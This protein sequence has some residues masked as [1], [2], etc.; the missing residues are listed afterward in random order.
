M[1][2][3]RSQENLFYTDKILEKKH[4]L[5]DNFRYPCNSEPY[6]SATLPFMNDHSRKNHRILLIFGDRWSEISIYYVMNKYTNN[7][8]IFKLL[9]LCFRKLYVCS[10]K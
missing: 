9:V 5:T 8:E 2:N 7:T 4:Q 6:F 10:I 3:R 1:K